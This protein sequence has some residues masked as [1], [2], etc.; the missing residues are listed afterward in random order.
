M[1]IMNKKLA[2][3]RY[4]KVLLQSPRNVLRTPLS[5]F[6]SS[7]FFQLCLFFFFFVQLCLILILGRPPPLFKQLTPIFS[8]CSFPC[9]SRH[10]LKTPEQLSVSFLFISSD[11]PKTAHFQ[12]HLAAQNRS[13]SGWS[14]EKKKFFSREGLHCSIKEKNKKY[15][16]TA[17]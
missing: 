2:W 14:E 5:P 8:A 13:F 3:K 7:S 17:L 1:K 15:I 12:S 6:F 9:F 11:R 4:L 10:P 16:Q